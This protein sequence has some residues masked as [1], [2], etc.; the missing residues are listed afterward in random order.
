MTT[1]MTRTKRMPEK[2]LLEICKRKG[3]SV[4]T[5]ESCTGGLVAKRITD[6]PG[7][8]SYFLMG[9][10]AYSNHAKMQLL[11]VKQDTLLMFGAVSRET[12]KEMAMGIL[13]L[14]DA[15]VGLGITGIAGPGGGT[16]EKPVGL[17]YLAVAS[18]GGNIKTEKHIFRGKRHEIRE[19]S[20]TRGLELLILASENY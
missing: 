15:D 1:P 5:A 8:S 16:P 12:V 7:A 2:H 6:V 3:I 10:V 11:G 9:V 4:A 19:K 14:A 18:R 13:R 17:V 20:A